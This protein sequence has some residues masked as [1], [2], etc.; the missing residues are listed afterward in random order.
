M[1]DDAASPQ[2]Q[3]SLDRDARP[4]GEPEQVLYRRRQ[5]DWLS[6]AATAGASSDEPETAARRAAIELAKATLIARDGLTSDHS[7]DVGL[8][9][10]AIARQLHLED[11]ERSDLMAAAQLHDIGKLGVP[12]SILQKPAPLTEGEWEIMRQHTPVGERILNAV[13]ELRDVA[14]IVRHSHEHWDGS[15]Y[16]D[17]LAGEDIPLAS[18]IILCAD[19]FHAVRSPRPYRSGRSARDAFDEVQ[20]N[21]GGQFDPAVVAALGRTVEDV[22]TP[23]SGERRFIPT[24]R[25][26]GT[27]RLAAL[28]LTLA[29]AGSA[30]AAPRLG[31][32]EAAADSAVE[33]GQNCSSLG[34]AVP[35]PAPGVAWSARTV[36]RQDRRRAAGLRL[37]A[38]RRRAANRRRAAGRRRSLGRSHGGQA[39]R[40]VRPAMKV[41]AAPKAPTRAVAPVPGNTPTPRD[42]STVL[43]AVR[44]VDAEVHRDPELAMKVES[45]VT[46][47]PTVPPAGGTQGPRGKGRA[48][49]HEKRL[50]NPQPPKSPPGRIKPKPNP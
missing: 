13:P 5:T 40:P 37:A 8:L 43:S 1:E 48:Y 3:P 46:G 6:G 23:R 45:L 31:D 2:T 28:L 33:C 35:V 39:V 34:A 17:G 4:G 47:P 20:A 9:C 15:G 44:S 36:A 18:R 30:I 21:T 22:R 12:E 38:G 10:E 50:V 7:D 16:P 11:Q 26:L 14:V 42:H 25:M 27:R 29:V 24:R 41:K 19:A 49:G 32:D